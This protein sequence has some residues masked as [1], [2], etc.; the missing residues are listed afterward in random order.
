MKKKVVIVI[1]LALSVILTL[2]LLVG[3]A[4]TTDS[5]FSQVMLAVE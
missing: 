5:A 1:A 4:K 2:T 3:C